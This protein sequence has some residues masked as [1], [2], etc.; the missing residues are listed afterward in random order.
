[1]ICHLVI[2]KDFVLKSLNRLERVRAGYTKVNNRIDISGGR[3]TDHNLFLVGDIFL[4]LICSDH[5]LSISVF[6]STTASLGG[7]VRASVNIGVM[8]AG[9]TTCKITGQ[10]LSLLAT[11]PSPGVSESFLWD[12]GYVEARLII[13]GTLEPTERMVV[14]T[15]PGSLVKPI[16]PEATFIC[17]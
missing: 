3:I 16:N 10:L 8:K 6:R 17:L 5:T 2:N 4:T 12:R 13:Q 7:V 1:M 9:R 15:V 14:V 11:H